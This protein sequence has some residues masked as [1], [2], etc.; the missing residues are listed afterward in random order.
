MTGIGEPGENRRFSNRNKRIKSKD[1]RCVRAFSAG[2]VFGFV[3]IRSEKIRRNGDGYQF[4]VIEKKR[5][6]VSP[7]LLHDRGIFIL[8]RVPG[9][10]ADPIQMRSAQI[11]DDEQPRAEAE[12]RPATFVRCGRNDLIFV[13]EQ[14]IPVIRRKRIGPQQKEGFVFRL[15]NIDSLRIR[16]GR[17]GFI[18]GK[19]DR[20][21]ALAIIAAEKHQ[22]DRLGIGKDEQNDRRQQQKDD[23]RQMFF[24]PFSHDVDNVKLR[25][26]KINKSWDIKPEKSYSFRKPLCF[27]RSN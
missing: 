21:S 13:D 8:Q 23:P 7:V 11:V 26:K 1:F 6:N 14:E 10:G 16:P 15:E 20:F 18:S 27:P 3:H 4:V 25:Q 2:A 24:Q 19:D 12:K 5:I 22:H 17:S 9:G